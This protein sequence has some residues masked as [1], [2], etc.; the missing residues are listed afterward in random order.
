[1]YKFKCTVTADRI[2]IF[3]DNRNVLLQDSLLSFIFTNYRFVT[4]SFI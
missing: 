1:M 4:F 3:A 2:K